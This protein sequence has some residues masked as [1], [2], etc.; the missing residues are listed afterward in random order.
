VEFRQP[1]AQ[2]RTPDDRFQAR[3]R[4]VPEITTVHFIFRAQSYSYRLGDDVP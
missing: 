2:M 3:I 4:Y 1:F